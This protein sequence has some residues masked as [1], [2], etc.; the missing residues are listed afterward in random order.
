MK[1]NVDSL[2]AAEPGQAY[3]VLKRMGA[4]P[5]ENSEDGSFELPE[6]V[7]LGL[8]AAQSADRLAQAFADISQ[9][10]P[11]LKPE[12]LPSRTQRLL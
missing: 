7:S 4:Q 11:P 9:E 8:S 3:K 2:M 10:F 5:G 12:N 1:K 6:Y